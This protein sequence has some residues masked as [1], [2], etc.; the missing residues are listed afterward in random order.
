MTMNGNRMFQAKAERSLKNSR[1][2][3]LKSV[4]ILFNISFP[5]S[6]PEL[7]TGELQKQVFEVLIPHIH[8]R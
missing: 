8:R 6:C 2:R 5:M 1:F 7:M 4:Q 3:A